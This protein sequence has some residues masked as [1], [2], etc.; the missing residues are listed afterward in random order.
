MAIFYY[1][2]RE[3]LIKTVKN[4]TTFS[5]PSGHGTLNFIMKTYIF[6]IFHTQ[7]NISCKK[8]MIV[9]ILIL[10]E[11]TLMHVPQNFENA[12]AQVLA[13]SHP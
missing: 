2:L 6:F 1:D 13:Q 7:I 8:R 10:F 12:P 9:V 3:K 11:F 4:L 5:D